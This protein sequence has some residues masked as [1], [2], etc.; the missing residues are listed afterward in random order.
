I[1]AGAALGVDLLEPLRESLVTIIVAKF[2]AMIVDAVRETLPEL[3]LHGLPRKF[4]R[5]LL[6]LAAKLLVRFVASRETDN[7]ERGRQIAVGGDVVK[8]RNKFAMREVARCAEDDDGAGLRHRTA[9]ETF[10]QRIG[11][12]LVGH[13][14]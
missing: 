1:A 10:A 14:R 3:V 2:A 9:R 11:L 5:R 4:L 12:R 13:G 6:E 8:R 7:G